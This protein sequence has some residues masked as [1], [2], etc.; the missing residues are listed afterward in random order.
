MDAFQVIIGNVLEDYISFM[1]FIIN[2]APAAIIAFPFSIGL[3]LLMY[4]KDLVGRW[5]KGM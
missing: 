5:G 1:D 2:L 4:K 3:A